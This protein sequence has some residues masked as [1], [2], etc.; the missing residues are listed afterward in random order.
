MRRQTAIVAVLG[1]SV[2]AAG[3]AGAKVTAVGTVTASDVRVP[4]DRGLELFGRGIGA[5]VAFFDSRGEPF[6]GYEIDTRF[7]LGENDERLYDLGVSLFAGPSVTRRAIAPFVAVGL[8]VA[9]VQQ[10][11]PAG[12]DRGVLLGVHG[13]LG[14]H[15]MT[16]KVYW[17]VSGGWLGAVGGLYAQVGLGFAFGDL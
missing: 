7:I 1:V 10:A 12:D 15:G 17:R 9:A 4:G 13:G 6:V 8:D 5:S 16:D 2:L 14:V 11:D 3:Q